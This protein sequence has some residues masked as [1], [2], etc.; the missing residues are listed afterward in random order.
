MSDRKCEHMWQDCV[1]NPAL[2]PEHDCLG[3]WNR[4]RD[5][6]STNMARHR[7]KAEVYETQLDAARKRCLELAPRNR[8][9]YVAWTDGQPTIKPIVVSDTHS[10]HLSFEGARNTV[11]DWWRNA[12]ASDFGT[13]RRP[14]PVRE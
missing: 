13:G 9:Y 2:L 1:P 6:L 7:T 5:F 14:R 8:S 11:I 4:Y 3:C 10:V 12:K